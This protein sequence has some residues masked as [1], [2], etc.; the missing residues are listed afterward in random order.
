MGKGPFADADAG[1]QAVFACR[2]E[3]NATVYPARCRFFGCIE[4]GC[5]AAV[6]ARQ[7]I[8][9]GCEGQIFCAVKQRE[10]SRSCSAECAMARDVIREGG[11]HDERHPVQFWFDEGN[12]SYRAPEVEGV[13]GV[14]R[15]NGSV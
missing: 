1:L 2:S 13:L 8:G 9:A 10:H 12:C 5:K 14:P 11:C 15:A 6:H 4:A 3:M 7:K